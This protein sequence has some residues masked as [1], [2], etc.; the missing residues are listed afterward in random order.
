MSFQTH[1]QNR[2]GAQR[3]SIHIIMC[4]L[5]AFEDF[6][7]LSCQVISLVMEINIF[8]IKINNNKFIVFK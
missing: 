4:L 5:V 8:I 6:S 1:T 3:Y 7:L 2:R